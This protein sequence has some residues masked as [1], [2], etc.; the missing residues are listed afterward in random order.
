MNTSSPVDYGASSFVDEPQVLW[1]RDAARDVDVPRG[2]GVGWA[3]R[4]G[5]EHGRLTLASE[6]LRLDA[7]QITTLLAST[8]GSGSFQQLA[9]AKDSVS[10]A[11]RLYAAGHVLVELDLTDH[12]GPDCVVGVAVELRGQGIAARVAVQPGLT[13]AERDAALAWAVAQ[14][15]DFLA[16]SQ[17]SSL[18]TH[19]WTQMAPSRWQ[20][21]ARTF[22]PISTEESI[23][24]S[25]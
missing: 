9:H 25:T 14:V 6:H 1:W 18:D 12:F 7:D 4:D 17:E 10:P 24:G 5:S 16:A 21:T 23:S 20:T 15:N 8:L 2:H 22:A 3:T 11:V 19:G 13:Q